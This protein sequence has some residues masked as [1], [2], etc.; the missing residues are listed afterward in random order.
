MDFLSSYLKVATWVKQCYLFCSFW[1]SSDGIGTLTVQ[2]YQSAKLLMACFY[3][4]WRRARK[5]PA[6]ALLQVQIWLR[7]STAG[8][9]E[10][11][12]TKSI[13]TLAG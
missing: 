10:G 13:P 7:D 8:G 1:L 5:R 3:E 11:Y 2:E 9:L 6:E 12:L 4:L